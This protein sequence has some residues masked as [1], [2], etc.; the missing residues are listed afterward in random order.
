PGPPPAMV[1]FGQVQQQELENQWEAIGRLHE[2]RRTL[3]ATETT[4]KIVQMPVTE[5]DAVIGGKTVLVKIDP[6]WVQLN[7]QQS[8]ADLQRSKA[9]VLEIEADY[10]QT[11]R[12]RQQLEELLAGGSAKPKEVDDARAA[13]KAGKARL[14]AAQ[15]AVLAAQATLDRIATEMQRLQVVAPFDGAVV[16]KL[17][18]V[19]QWAA[20][21]TPVA[22]IVSTGRIDALIDVPERMVNQL[23]I[24]RTVEVVIEP[25]AA[26]A[27]RV[28]G[29]VRAIVPE[30]V[31]SARTFPVKIELDDQAGQL[32][33]GMSV[34]A[35][36]P[37]GEKTKVL[38]VPRDAVVAQGM[39][40][41]IWANVNGKALPIAV[42]VLFSHGGRYAVQT[43]P[44]NAGPPLAPGM[45]V[46][47]EGAERL[48]P[49]APVMA[50]A[51]EAQAPATAPAT[52][53]H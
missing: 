40:Q 26:G 46:V 30:G 50:V 44:S 31:N 7:D 43:A 19:G 39:G 47:I 14:E 12:D 42:E 21:G 38:T 10:D 13:E 18:E 51:A 17:I 28:T 32:K 36:V 8:R 2:Q 4:G 25:L 9:T 53:D 27:R 15:A 16:R 37:M 45:Q 5:G 35:Q 34:V 29:K 52:T 48:W 11:Q 6:V 1:R 20:V 24:G 22:E 33:P 3:V 23:A 49:T 41:V